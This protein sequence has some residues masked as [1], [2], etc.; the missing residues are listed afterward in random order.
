M[1]VSPQVWYTDVVTVTDKVMPLCL[2]WCER[3]SPLHPA[4]W[5]CALICDRATSKNSIWR[6]TGIDR[7]WERVERDRQGD[8]DRFGPPRVGYIWSFHHLHSL[9]VSTLS[10]FYISSSH[11]HTSRALSPRCHLSSIPSFTKSLF[12]PSIS[13]APP[14]S[15]APLSFCAHI[16]THIIAELGVEAGTAAITQTRQSRAEKESFDRSGKS[17]RRRK[18]HMVTL[19]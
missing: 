19:D 18:S 3:H 11:S 9:C 13:L 14:L 15:L 16:G 7:Q 6:K 17:G 8:M 4:L 1:S 12:T 2:I 5:F 10:H